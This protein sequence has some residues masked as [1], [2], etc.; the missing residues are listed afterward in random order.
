MGSNGSTRGDRGRRARSMVHSPAFEV[1]DLC[2][3][4]VFLVL[5]IGETRKPRV[6]P[7]EPDF[8]IWGGAGTRRTVLFSGNNPTLIRGLYVSAHLLRSHIPG[9]EAAWHLSGHQTKE[10]RASPLN[11]GVRPQK[12]GLEPPNAPS[13]HLQVDEYITT[14]LKGRECCPYLDFGGV[15]ARFAPSCH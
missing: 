4:H 8:A 9:D 5:F 6:T 10:W 13:P 2:S 3:L 11:S 15:W 14:H 1:T 12:V 7:Y